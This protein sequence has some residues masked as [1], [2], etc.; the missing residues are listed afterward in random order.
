MASGIGRVT[1]TFSNQ[2]KAAAD[3]LKKAASQAES[4]VAATVNK[5]ASRA[6]KAG[7]DM[8]AKHLSVIANA[9]HRELARAGTSL[10]QLKTELASVEIRIKELLKE[11]QTTRTS[12]TSEKERMQSAQETE[13]KVMENLQKAADAL[14]ELRKSISLL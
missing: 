2:A 4:A 11:I 8:A 3:Q 13:Q 6:V 1:K 9:S 12:E 5:P 7:Q 14:A 10:S